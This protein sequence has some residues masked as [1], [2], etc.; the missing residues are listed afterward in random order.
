[1][2]F[3]SES[4]WVFSLNHVKLWS[5]REP[6]ARNDPRQFRR[7]M[8]QVIDGS[9]QDKSDQFLTI[10]ELSISILA[11]ILNMLFSPGIFDLYWIDPHKLKLLIKQGCYCFFIT[12]WDFGDD[13]TEFILS[14]S[15]LWFLATVNLILTL[16]NHLYDIKRLYIT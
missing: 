3:F 9:I 7:M 16:L 5:P 14:V 6:Q 10:M 15:L 1:M 12:G 13:C 8:N 2:L 11:W 4:E